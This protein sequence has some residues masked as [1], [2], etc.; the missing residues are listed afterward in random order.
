MDKVYFDL[1]QR[2]IKLL[3]TPDSKGREPKRVLIAIA[4]PPGSGKTT[5]AQQV[6]KLINT[7]HPAPASASSNSKTAAPTALP[8]S[9]DG[10]HLRRSELASM[11]DPDEAFRRRGAPWTFDAEGMVAF[12]SHC[13]Q[14]TTTST[15]S[16][17][18]V[19]DLTAPTFDHAVKDPVPDGLRIPATTRVLLLEGNYLLVDEPPWE[20]IAELVDERWYINVDVAAA[21]ERTAAR[22]VR[23]GV[24]ADMQAALG[25]VE[26]N[27]EPNAEY[28]REHLH[29]V[30]Y[31]I[32]SV[33]EPMHE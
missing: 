16:S 7:Q 21:R 32:E 29:S 31:V 26:G 27:D 12:I 8:V 24:E 33:D 4:G 17:S 20:A 28:I 13:H 15:T 11:D 6:A 5:T 9:M 19:T 1:A 23:T 22:H 25:R 10:F 2:A 30:D 14:T 3:H 18:A